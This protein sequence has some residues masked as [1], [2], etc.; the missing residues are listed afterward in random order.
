MVCLGRNEVELSTTQ[1][2][3]ECHSDQLQWGVSRGRVV[4]DV[5]LCGLCNHREKVEDW[6]APCS[7]L[8]PSSCAN[9]GH[10]ER[11]DPCLGCGLTAEEDR[12]VHLE[13]R[14]FIPD[15]TDFLSAARKANKLGRRVLA[16]KLATAA[17]LY[18]DVSRREAA[19]ALR[20]WLLAAIGEQQAAY[21]DAKAWVDQSKAPSQLAWGS[22]GQQCEQLNLYGDATDAFGKALEVDPTQHLIRCRRA[23]LLL[24]QNRDGQALAEV[25]KLFELTSEKDVP[26]NALHVAAHVLD[27]LEKHNNS[28]DSARL[29]SLMAGNVNQS[30][31]LL[32]HAARINALAGKAKEARQQLDKARKLDPNLAIYTRVE[33]L[34]N[35]GGAGG[36]R[37]W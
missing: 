3:S 11:Q 7:P 12:E 9:C 28:D 20:V 29:L 31:A 15:E 27:R 23:E 6:T 30:P 2:C 8:A 26:K 21:N 1:R 25:Y 10:P 18:G 17:C 24:R 36:W 34:L 35:R 4:A 16:L 19:R 32:G 33:T 22:L 14:E 37:K 13:L 5:L